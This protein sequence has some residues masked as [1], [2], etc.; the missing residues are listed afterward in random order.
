MPNITQE[1]QSE[2]QDGSLT[3]G[4]LDGGIGD[5]SIEIAAD[6][7]II[8]EWNTRTVFEALEPM[9]AVCHGEGQSSPYFASLSNFV[10]TIVADEAYVVLG[11]PD[12]SELLSLLAGSFNGPLTQM[13]PSGDTY[14]SRI[15]GDLSKP[16]LEDLRGWIARLSSVPSI[17]DQRTCATTHAPK[18]LHR[19][20]RLE[21]NRSVQTLLGTTQEPANDFPSEDQS[22]GFDNIA[23]ALAVS[24]LLVEKYD[25][26]AQALAEEALPAPSAPRQTYFFEA[27]S[28]MTASTGGPAGEGWNLWSNGSLTAN[29]NLPAPGRYQIVA[30]ARQQQAGPDPAEARFTIDGRGVHTF[31]VTSTQR[32]E[33]QFNAIELEAGFHIIGIEFL[34]DYYCPQTRFDSGQCGNGDASLIGDRNLVVD[35]VSLEGPLDGQPVHSRF[36][37][38]FLQD[39]DLTTGPNAYTCARNALDRFARF[40]WRRPITQ[41]ESDRLWTLASAEFDQEHGLTTGLRQALH[42]ILLSPIFCLELNN[43]VHRVVP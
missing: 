32:A 5:Q 23:Q 37:D 31:D 17:D 29:V 6:A 43:P 40:A 38:T 2:G 22:F 42:A 27:E 4:Q 10:D 35:W 25:L 34:N 15:E 16:N 8:P 39:C 13:P 41:N 20:N 24:P 28:E 1:P 14:F 19:L 11:D 7:E 30:F 36:T 33:Y 12:E 3:R 18:L 9:C 26:A 21:Y